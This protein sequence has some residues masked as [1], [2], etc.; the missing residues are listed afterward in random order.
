MKKWKQNTF[1]K[2]MLRYSYLLLT[3]MVLFSLL[4]LAVVRGNRVISEVID[5][6]LVGEKVVFRSFLLEFLLLTLAGF[7]AAFAANMMASKFA[8]LVTTRYRKQ[9]ADKLYRL[10]YKYYDEHYSSSVINKINADLGEA[11]IFLQES[12]PTLLT[13][14]LAVIIY[15]NYVRQLSGRLFLVVVLCYPIVFGIASVLRQ[16]ITEL[17]KTYRA[18]TDAIMEVDQN[19]ISGIQIVKTFELQEYFTCKMHEATVA[20]VDNEE[21]RTRI[22]NTAMIIRKLVQWLPN[23]ICAIYSITLVRDGALSVGELLAFVIVLGKLVSAFVG[24]PFGFVDAAGHIVCI[25]R[26]E[27]ILTSPNECFGTA[28]PSI[29]EDTV[30]AFDNVSFGYHADDMVLDGLS[31]YVRRGENVAFVGESGGGKS[32][33]FHIICGFYHVLKGQ[34]RLYGQNIEE[35]DIESARDCFA[36]VSQNVFLFPVSVE[37]NI[38]YGNESATHEQVVEACKEAEIHDFIMTLPKQYQTVVGERGSLLSGGQKQRI[39]IARAILK[40]APILLL[41]EP[42]SAID[43]ETEEQI[44]RALNRLSHGKTC[45]TIAH[46]LST[47]KASDRIMVLKDG[48]IA[49]SGTHEGL[50]EQ[51]GLYASMYRS[52]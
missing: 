52:A 45:I 5:R 1:V 50:M 19:A 27:E 3:T 6:M 8:L 4:N 41:D 12:L 24:L 21:K 40:D 42:T 11:E 20:L 31:F 46:R 28:V 37:E 26:I 44:Q 34:Y 36:L 14:L 17:S 18:K 10:E 9:V 2:N 22:S 49:E 43:E 23:I 51:N 48:K 30:L 38:L 35:W 7:T 25:G 33:I 29:K 39:S 15:A 47:I 13:D 32:T 16:R